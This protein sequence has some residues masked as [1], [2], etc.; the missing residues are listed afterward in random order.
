M[1]EIIKFR[2][3]E[4]KRGVKE[5]ITE[6][7]CDELDQKYESMIFEKEEIQLQ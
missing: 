7:D 4:N 5:L 6:E 3:S 1:N 2:V